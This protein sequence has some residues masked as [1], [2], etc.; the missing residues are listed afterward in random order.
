M[1][2]PHLFIIYHVLQ[3]MDHDLPHLLLHRRH[4]FPGLFIE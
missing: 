3:K 4:Q 1:G 2:A